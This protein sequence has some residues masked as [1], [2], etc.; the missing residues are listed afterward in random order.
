MLYE[1][2]RR[3]MERS[4]E[5]KDYREE[6]WYQHNLKRERCYDLGRKNATKFCAGIEIGVQDL[7]D[8]CKGEYLRI[9]Q[10]S[11]NQHVHDLSLKSKDFF[12][13]P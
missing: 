5:Y 3:F 8:C 13:S 9:Y 7:E 11:F 2:D 4:Q 10:S 12:K 1:E 6:R